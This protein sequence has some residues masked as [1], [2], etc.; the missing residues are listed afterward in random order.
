MD[1]RADIAVIPPRRGRATS[2]HHLNQHCNGLTS[3][4]C[5]GM[6][7]RAASPSA[8]IPT[9][10][11]GRPPTGIINHRLGRQRPLSMRLRRCWVDDRHRKSGERWIHWRAF[12]WIT[13]FPAWWGSDM[14]AG[15]P[16]DDAVQP[17]YP[18]KARNYIGHHHERTAGW[19]DGDFNY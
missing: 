16:V 3:E 15:Y 18:E 13:N 5:A 12:P 6:A 1:P 7:R 9:N 14:M 10:T 2:S 8:A 17:A 19:T 11:P 4:P